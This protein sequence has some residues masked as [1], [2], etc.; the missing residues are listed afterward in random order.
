MIGERSR[1]SAALM[2]CSI[3][4]LLVAGVVCF[5]HLWPDEGLARRRAQVEGFTAAEREE[6]WE[7][8]KRFANFSPAEQARIV[9]A[10]GAHGFVVGAEAG[11]ACAFVLERENGRERGRPEDELT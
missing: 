9:P 6:L 5:A 11:V 2:V 10:E 8:Q 3:A 1:R 4:G 7:H